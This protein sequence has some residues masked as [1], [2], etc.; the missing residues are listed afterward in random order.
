MKTVSQVRHKPKE[1][2]RLQQMR[3]EAGIGVRELGQFS[4][5]SPAT[6][7]RVEQGGAPDITTALRLATFFE[8]SVEDLFGRFRE[9][10]RGA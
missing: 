7:T 6:I 5:L 10:R 1:R 8:T 9:R 3:D 4:G 2:T